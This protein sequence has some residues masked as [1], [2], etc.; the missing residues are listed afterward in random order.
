MPRKSMKGKTVAMIC[1]KHGFIKGDR[2]PIC[3]QNKAR[4]GV[5]IEIFKPMVYTDICETPILIESKRQLRE[6]CRK[7]NVIACRLM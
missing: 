5:Y 2:C 3:S 4:E 1:Q 6:E 7:H